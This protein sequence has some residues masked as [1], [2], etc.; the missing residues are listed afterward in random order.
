MVG[1][2]AIFPHRAMDQNYKGPGPSIHIR[3]GCP[4]DSDVPRFLL[5]SETFYQKEHR[6]DNKCR[7]ATLEDTCSWG[8][9]STS[10]F[11][12]RQ[13]ISQRADGQTESCEA[14]IHLH[15]RRIASAHLAVRVE[16]FDR[17]EIT[18]GKCGAGWRGELNPLLAWR[19]SGALSAAASSPRN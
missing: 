2:F 19:G 3:K 11:L 14:T 13:G 9:H 6:C 7:I 1:R 4:V 17:A 8:T 18:I 15:S 12:S 10:Q 5:G 16:V